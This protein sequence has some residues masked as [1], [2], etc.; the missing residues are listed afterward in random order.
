MHVLIDVILIAVLLFSTVKHWRLGLM[1][2]VYNIGKFIAS[3]LAAVIL[4][5][6]IGCMLA[7][8]VIGNAIENGVY[9]KLVI[10]A[11]EE[12]SL[13]ALLNSAPERFQSF[14]KLFDA[15]LAVLQSRFGN[16]EDSEEV[17]REMAEVIAYPLSGIV[18]AIVAYAAVFL[19]A[20]LV[21]SLVVMGL[22]KI[23]IPILSGIDKLLGLV[24]G[25]F[26]GLL[27]AAM[28]S[29]V[30]FSGI[31]LFAA[32]GENAEIWRIY[33]DSH[34]FRFIYELRIFEFVRN[35]I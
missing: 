25:L 33:T 29:T 5:R 22:K 24:L 32:T 3:V 19:V 9:D 15:D 12:G 35:L 20:Y 8:G 6:P 18:S 26:L 10:F 13:S 17:L 7:D 23:K 28:V 1:H 11:G 14:L 21:L 16:A 27:S 4:G 2:T 30:L 31:Q 34:V